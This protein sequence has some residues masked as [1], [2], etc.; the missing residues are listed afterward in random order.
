[1]KSQTIEQKL[2]W[3]I[4][5]TRSDE[6]DQNKKTKKTRWQNSEN[7]LKLAKRDRME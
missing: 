5:T 4:P 6:L 2:P 3:K 7:Y 1:M